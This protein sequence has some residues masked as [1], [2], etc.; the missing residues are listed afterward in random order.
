[1]PLR[2]KAF[3]SYSHSDSKVAKWLHGTLEKFKTPNH[4]VGQAGPTGDVP[5]RL[6][7]IFMDREELASSP[8]LSSN[9][10]SALRDSENLIVIC[11]PAAAKSRWVN[12][13]IQS[14]K[15]MGRSAKIYCLIL[16]GD[17]SDRGG[18]N[19]PFP[20]ALRSRFNDSGE[21]LSDE[22]ETIA[23]DLRPGTDGKQL[24]RQKIIAGLLGVQLDDL[25]RR[26]AQRRQRQLAIV[27]ISSA[28]IAAST[29]AL[30]A[31]AYIARN[32]A[33]YQRE[34][35]ESLIVYM[36]GDLRERLQPVGRLDVLDGV[37]EK[38]L[39]YFSNLPES[40]LTADAQIIRA[41]ALRQIGE[42]RVFQGRTPEGLI[43]FLQALEI[44]DNKASLT[45]PKRLYELGQI[46]F[47]LANAYFEEVDLNPAK[48]HINQYL[49]YS[50]QL[51]RLSPEVPE[52]QMEL[53]YAESNLG[54]LAYLANNR[55]LARL[56]FER[57]L[58]AVDELVRSQASDEIELERAI[59]ISWLAAIDVADGKF[60][61]A[62]S[63]YDQELAIH[64]A[65]AAGTSNPAPKR[66]LARTLNQLA[67]LH[68][69][70]GTPDRSIAHLDESLSIF[71]GLVMHDPQNS[72]WQRMF[73]WSLILRASSGYAAG[74]T[75]APEA[76]KMLI[77]ADENLQS[78]NQN[79]TAETV[80]IAASMLVELAYIEL[81]SGNHS[82]AIPHLN[83]AQELL[84]P[85]VTS[86][87]RVR[88]LPLYARTLYLTSES[89]Q[90]L[91]GNDRAA[92]TASAG[93]HVLSLKDNDHVVLISYGALIAKIARQDDAERLAGIVSSTEFRG[94]ALLTSTKTHSWWRAK[95]D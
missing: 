82:T 41:K 9:I 25:R 31:L 16:S 30:A 61:S 4:L 62:A 22:D 51:V 79:Q 86:K 37:G 20:P 23:A 85:F 26:E 38:A 28:I 64:R 58:A 75:S 27:A 33:E 65:V 66:E 10:D 35:A 76:R 47:W 69:L 89:D 68:G 15:M 87:D 3:I 39:E 19:D 48:L 8:D 70:E 46:H 36:L 60:T 83:K 32:D 91:Y 72:D 50:R 56:H 29:I 13:E 49:E 63:W 92:E 84:Q 40:K 18:P 53:V 11:S 77:D 5:A 43:A 81:A 54:T 1:M 6:T 52:Y 59:T 88:I 44:L 93:L 73:A 94:S 55:Q 71:K 78:S 12:L 80:K 21:I 17:P 2:Y 7:P 90:F 57:A 74:V 42:V 14:F 95:F 34:Q 45:D 24:A 67:K